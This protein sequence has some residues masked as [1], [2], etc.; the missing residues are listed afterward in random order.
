M[1]NVL[2]ISLRG[3]G[4]RSR[5]FRRA[6]DG[7]VLLAIDTSAVPIALPETRRLEALSWGDDYQLLF[8]LPPGIQPPATATQVGQVEPLGFVPLF[9]DGQPIANAAGLGWQHN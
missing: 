4:E 3:E 5:A 9:V 7:R 2:N 8:T 6:Y 1:C